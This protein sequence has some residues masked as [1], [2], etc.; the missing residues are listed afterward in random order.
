MERGVGTDLTK[1]GLT[2]LWST[3]HFDKI[4]ILMLSFREKYGHLPTI[5]HYGDQIRIMKELISIGASELVRDVGDMMFI[6]EALMDAHQ[7]N[8]VFEFTEKDRVTFIA[9]INLMREI[10]KKV[11]EI[12]SFIEDGMIG[13]FE[14]FGFDMDE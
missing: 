12:S 6:L 2:F 8:G 10:G 1:T 3:L 11:P 9:F 7:D 14:A 4:N 5:M 13:T